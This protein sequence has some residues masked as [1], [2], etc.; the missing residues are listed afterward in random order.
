MLNTEVVWVFEEG[1]YN[2]GQ[3]K[4]SNIGETNEGKADSLTGGI[5]KDNQDNMTWKGSIYKINQELGNW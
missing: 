1:Q 5:N 3:L 4:H 2:E